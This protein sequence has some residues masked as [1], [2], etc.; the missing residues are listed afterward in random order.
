MRAIS[1]SNDAAMFRMSD[2][3]EDIMLQVVA[4]V[5]NSSAY[6]LQQDELTDVTSCSQVIVCVCYIDK[7]AGKDQYLLSDPLATTTR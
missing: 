3:S 6:L 7:E 1:L 2:I 4:A 5:R